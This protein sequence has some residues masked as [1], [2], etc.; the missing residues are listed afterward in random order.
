MPHFQAVYYRDVKGVEPVNKFIENLDSDR[1]VVLENQI[2]RLN[3]L[4]DQIPHLPFPHTSQVE[5]ELREL[6]AHYGREH[7]RV[8]YRRSGRLIVL[9]HM[10]EKRS[11]KIPE[12]EK[13]IARSAGLI[14]GIVWTHSPGPRLEPPATTLREGSY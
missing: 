2:D 6:R 7:Y 9:L 1:Q 10:F 3:L 4:S 5:G 11:G 8:L 13:R 14:S 12:G